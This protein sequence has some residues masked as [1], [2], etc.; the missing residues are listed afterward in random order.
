[1]D[2][3]YMPLK[4]L[5]EYAID[6]NTQ[7]FC[8][9]FIVFINNIIHMWYMIHNTLMIGERLS[10]GG[11]PPT[12]TALGLSSAAIIHS[13]CSPMPIHYHLASGSIVSPQPG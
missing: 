6:C 13:Q 3:G 8:S 10:R 5:Y 11:F 2:E 12:A 9:Q 4:P 7:R 1:M